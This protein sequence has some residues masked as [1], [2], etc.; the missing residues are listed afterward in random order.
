VARLTKALRLA[1]AAIERGDLKAVQALVSVVN[2]LDR[3]H[4]LNERR[5][6]LAR[7]GS[8]A[9]LAPP[10]APALPPPALELAHVSLPAT[11]REPDGVPAGEPAD[12]SENVIT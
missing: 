2:S 5:S 9:V 12:D 1:D 7:S 10:V 3:Y 6:S 4:G 8:F 11:G